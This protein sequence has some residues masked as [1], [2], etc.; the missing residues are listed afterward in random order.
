MNNNLIQNPIKLIVDYNSVNGDGNFIYILNDNNEL[1]VG[2]LLLEQGITGF[3]RFKFNDGIVNDF[4]VRDNKLFF[5]IKRD[6][7]F[8]IEQLDDLMMVDYSMSTSLLDM[9]DYYEINFNPFYKNKEV[10]IYSNNPSFWYYKAIVSTDL[11]VEIIKDKMPI[12]NPSPTVTYGLPI[13]S[14]LKVNNVD[15]NGLTYS[16]QKRI[17]NID[18]LVSN[19]D[20][21]INVNGRYLYNYTTY[22]ESNNRLYRMP[23]ATNFSRE[24]NYT[25]K[26][27]IGNLEIKSLTETIN[28]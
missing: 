6:D 19:I 14:I 12:D 22:T 28:Y 4:Y 24:C 8:S 21:N 20:N 1:I 26:N 11:K 5:I 25:I 27:E 13:E 2:Q 10:I 18:I 17:A 23:G 9:G 3:T 7:S 15:I 16:K